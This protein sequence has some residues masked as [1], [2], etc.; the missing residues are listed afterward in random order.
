MDQT[1]G[2]RRPPKSESWA[3]KSQLLWGA[4]AAEEGC[5]AVGIQEAARAM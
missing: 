2:Q 4:E 5:N 3:C 1:A